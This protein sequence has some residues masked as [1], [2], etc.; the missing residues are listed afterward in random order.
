MKHLTL[1]TIR[2]FK[3]VSILAFIVVG[4]FWLFAPHAHA[5]TVELTVN[6]GSNAS[7]TNGQS[8]LLEWYINGAVSNC[9]INNGV[10]P[11]ST[12]VLPAIGSL[13]V[14]PPD[15]STTNYSLTCN[16][17]SSVAT[18]AINPIVTLT[19][20]DTTVDLDP[21]DNDA[22]VE[23]HWESRYATECT[24]VWYVKASSPSTQIWSGAYGDQ[25]LTAGWVDIDITENTTFYIQCT[26][27][28]T[29][30]SSVASVA[31]TVNTPA[32]QPAPTVYIESTRGSGITTVT[33]DATTAAAWISL[34][35]KGKDVDECAFQAY[36]Q[37][38]TPYASLPSDFD[39]YG[40]PTDD[41]KGN[42]YWI[43]IYE[44]TRFE[45]TCTQ[46]AYT[47]GGTNYPATS[48]T[49]DITITVN[50]PLPLNRTGIA[51]VTMSFTA[52]QNP[53]YTNSLTEIAQVPIQVVTTN[54]ERCHYWAFGTTPDGDPIYGGAD[55]WW[56]QNNSG[57][58]NEVQLVNLEAGTTT[59]YGRCER[60]F[61][62][63]NFNP[64]DP[65]YEVA[66]A[67]AEIEIVAIENTTPIPDPEV[68]MYG[69]VSYMDVD[70]MWSNR[71]ALTQF[72]Y[73]SGYGYAYEMDPSLRAP[74]SGGGS[75]FNINASI[76]FPFQ[77]PDKVS[78]EYDLIV[79]YCDESDGFVDYTLTT[80]SGFSTTWRSDSGA[81]Y[82]AWCSGDD[83]ETVKIIATDL[84]IDDGELITVSCNNAADPIKG[85]QCSFIAVIAG[86]N[87]G[88]YVE[89]VPSAVTGFA[90]APVFWGS[91]YA[92]D[93]GLAVATAP[94]GASYTYTP[95]TPRD[96]YDTYDIATTT[97]FSIRCERGGIQKSTS[98][99]VRLPAGEAIGA[100][101]SIDVFEC[102][103][104]SIPGVRDTEPWEWANPSNSNFCEPAV[105]LNA[106]APSIS[107][108]DAIPDN[109]SGLYDSLEAII[110]IE[111][112]GP[113]PL[114][115]GNEIQ[116]LGRLNLQAEIATLFGISNPLE[117]VSLP[118]YTSGL[119]M[120]PAVTDILTRTF[121][122]VPFGQ[123]T[124]C[125][126]INIDGANGLIF[127]EWNSNPA[128][129]NV[130][131]TVT[132]PVPPP[133][134]AIS[135]DRR[136]I[137][138][139]QTADITWTAHTSYPLSCT[140]LGPGGIN[141]TFDASSNHPSPVSI[142]QSTAPLTNSGRYT[143]TCNEPITNTTFT[144]AIVVEVVPE[145]EEI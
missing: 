26:N 46:F 28:V 139:G 13:T 104:P 38:G 48:V 61:D 23:L 40:N 78:D 33:R 41:K 16:G 126:R 17:G 142:V 52:L 5:Q 92:E 111:N 58:K 9:V 7:I 43:T 59:L 128:N 102:Y 94:N 87:N 66:Y 76:T 57:S 133:P 1:L 11:I 3:N 112:L 79:K 62:L 8:V 4:L 12:A 22:K 14:T 74:N 123:H 93:C 2:Q 31:V 103:D 138:S 96:Y 107:F 81:Q 97:T 86:Q 55:G 50:P 82:N 134:M 141:N 72:G 54:A 84:T 32:P 34:Y 73:N 75:N 85:D 71:T 51:P 140:V 39:R 37:N 114:L 117:T 18:V 130:C 124:L 119:G 113:G 30:A 110:A 24:R 135:A 27:V 116:F 137:R 101:A 42:F 99:Q 29:G 49:D 95:D 21:V 56:G 120:P 136:V 98:L 19:A 68:F 132:L 44:T 108:D 115:A 35:Y 143:L 45:V 6:G 80:E 20:E 106:L 90:D 83:E 53:V 64:G 10:G 109:I 25:Y 100:E 118:G 125:A 121:D 105:D 91:L 88:G 36:Y 63:M 144:E 145:Q 77:S 89:E 67:E 127:T 65:E 129:N 60:P 47:L 70:Y 15:S 122:G 131:T 69:N